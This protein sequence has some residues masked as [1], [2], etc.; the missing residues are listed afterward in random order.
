MYHGVP[1]TMPLAAAPARV[2]VASAAGSR[3]VVAWAGPWPSEERWWDE[4]RVRRRARFQLLTEDGAGY[5]AVV[6]GGRWWVEATY[7]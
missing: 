3:A 4:H 5:L 1:A 7:D 2:S 6:E